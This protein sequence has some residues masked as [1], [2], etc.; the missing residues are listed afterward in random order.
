MYE[1]LVMAG[2]HCDRRRIGAYHHMLLYI[3]YLLFRK[4]LQIL[5]NFRRNVSWKAGNS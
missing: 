1:L 2:L 4:K 3:N 5:L